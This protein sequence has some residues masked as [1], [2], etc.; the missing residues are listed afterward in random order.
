MFVLVQRRRP[1]R[2]IALDLVPIA[3]VM[4]MQMTMRDP[5]RMP[6]QMKMPMMRVPVMFFPVK[7]PQRENRNPC[8]KKYQRAARDISNRPA[9][10]LRRKYSH[11]PHDKG[12]SQ[13][14]ERMAESRA[15][16]N[17]G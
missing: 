3:I 15:C 2:E 12:E 6:V 8:A 1:N 5:V 9:Q 4:R 14:R 10:T 11:E 16:G 13:R 17:A 7:V